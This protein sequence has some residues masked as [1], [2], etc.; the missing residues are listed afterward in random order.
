MH[1]LLEK[2]FASKAFVNSNNELVEVHSETSQ[3]Q[4]EFL[5]KIII[6]NHFSQ[7][8]EIGFAYGISTLAILEVVSKNA[9]RHFVIDK[10]QHSGWGD[11]GLDLI[12]Q[13]GYQEFL[14]FS[15]DFCYEIL[16]K[17]H[18]DNRK[19]D[20]AYIDSSKQ[21]DWI[22]VD[23]FYLDKILQ[24]GGVVVFDDVSFPG[25]R[26]VL[27]YVSQFPNYEVYAQFPPNQEETSLRKLANLLTK[28]PK[29][30]KILKEE[31]L[32]S[33]QQ[34]GINSRCVALRKTGEDQRNYDWHVSF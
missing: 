8:I 18:F 9:G 19:F 11:N 10:F 22:L 20:F 7:S 25:I 23:F 34:L 12:K 31:L 21:F 32:L 15:D 29:T 5:Q 4:C 14:D 24:T 6:D 26:K 16:P 1:T 2:I 30:D 28:L 33:D 17:L 13:A 27:R 3:Y